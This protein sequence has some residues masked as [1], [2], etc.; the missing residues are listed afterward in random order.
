[1][2]FPVVV[3]ILVVVAQMTTG[4]KLVSLDSQFRVPNLRLVNGL[5]SRETELEGK[6][7][8]Y[9]YGSESNENPGIITRFAVMRVSI[10]NGLV[11][12]I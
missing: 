7:K 4:K 11:W 9:W 8:R 12:Y 1:M 2:I 5:L 10:N 6:A 3:E